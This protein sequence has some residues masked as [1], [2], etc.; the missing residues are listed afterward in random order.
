MADILILDTQAKLR[1]QLLRLLEQAGHRATAVATVSEASSILQADAPDVLAT[2]VVLT[3]GSSTSLTK[4][5]EGERSKHEPSAVCSRPTSA[6]G[7]SPAPKGVAVAQRLA[8]Y[9]LPPPPTPFPP[10]CSGMFPS[11]SG[12]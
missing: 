3:D 11:F 2:D 8:S 1:Q 7:C 4:E 6:G 9:I 12:E 10:P 5:A